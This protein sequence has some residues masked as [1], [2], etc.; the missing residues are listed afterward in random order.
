MSLAPVALEVAVVDGVEAH[1]RREEAHVGLGDVVADEVATGRQALLE[2]VEVL[3][4]PAVGLVVGILGAGEAAAV[5]TVVDVAV[6]RLADRLDLVGEGSGVEVRRALAV[7]VAPLGLE[8]DGDLLEVVRHDSTGGHVHDRG[9]RDATGVFG[10]A[11]EVGVLDAGDLQ[12]RVEAAGIEVE[13]PGCAGR[14]SGRRSPSTVRPRARA[15]GA[16]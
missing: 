10:V 12:H 6:D 16:R 3:P 2:Q 11:L 4:Q 5:D 8:V 7:E 15:A 13:G 9:H 14:A 1:E